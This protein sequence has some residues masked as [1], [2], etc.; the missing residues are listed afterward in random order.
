MI[1][2]SFSIAFWPAPYCVL[3]CSVAE[4]A[5]NEWAMEDVA[6]GGRI[7]GRDV[8]L[9]RS[10]VFLMVFVSICDVLIQSAMC[11]IAIFSISST[12]NRTSWVQQHEPG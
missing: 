3:A 6:R 10:G 8:R 12:R 1:A 2:N 5:V 11:T 7:K 4:I 9:G